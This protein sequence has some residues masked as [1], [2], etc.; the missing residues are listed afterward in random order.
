MERLYQKR[1]GLPGVPFISG[2]PGEDGTGGN[3]VYFGYIN[4][5]FDVIDVSVDSIVRAASTELGQHYTGVY[6][7]S[8]NLASDV[9]PEG[10]RYVEISEDP[11]FPG[12][13]SGSYQ[14]EETISREY[15]KADTA[16]IGKDASGNI[17]PWNVSLGPDRWK[18]S[19]PS[20]LM[21]THGHLWPGQPWNNSS[22]GP[23]IP[24]DGNLDTSLRMMPGRY[25]LSLA[26]KNG[27]DLFTA[28]S[29]QSVYQFAL[30]P[31]T[32]FYDK[33][34]DGFDDSSLHNIDNPSIG[35]LENDYASEGGLRLKTD[36]IKYAASVD[37][38]MQVPD[39][40]KEDIKAGDVIYFYT[41]EDD[42]Q[43]TGK[44]E[45]MTVITE[46]LEKCSYQDLIDNAVMTDPFSFK[47]FDEKASTKDG[48]LYSTL[49]AVTG[50]Y[51]TENGDDIKD[52][53]AYGRNMVNLL[54]CLGKDVTFHSGTLSKKNSQ[55][56][57]NMMLFVQNSGDTINSKMTFL[58]KPGDDSKI[59]IDTFSSKSA[60]TPML[61][62][63]RAYIRKDN[64]GNVETDF[65]ANPEGYK[66][67]DNGYIH[68]LDDSDYVASESTFYVKPSSYFYDLDSKWRLGV[69][70]ETYNQKLYYSEGR[71]VPLTAKQMKLNDNTV[72]NFTWSYDYSG[73]TAFRL[74]MKYG[75]D[76]MHVITVWA[77]LP[78]SL[79]KTSR[80][81]K[82]QYSIEAGGFVLSELWPSADSSSDDSKT[83]EPKFVV[84]SVSAESIKDAP[85]DIIIPYEANQDIKVF[86]NTTRIT[87]LL[88]YSS[89][90]V[91]GHGSW[92]V[93]TMDP[94]S[95]DDVK[96][97]YLTIHLK[98]TMTSNLPTIGGS[99]E[100]AADYNASPGSNTATIANG[101]DIFN[102]LIEGDSI[103]TEDRSL[104]IS[105]NYSYNGAHHD[106]FTKVVQPG[107]KDLRKIPNVGVSIKKDIRSLEDANRSDL[108]VTS[109]EFQF[110]VEVSID[111]FDQSIWGS[112]VPED[113]IRL[114]ME[115]RNM[116]V[117]YDFVEK[118]GIQ[119][120]QQTRT[121]HVNTVADE[122]FNNNYVRFKTYVMDPSFSTYRGKTQSELDDY[123][124]KSEL[125]SAQDNV[126]N[127]EDGRVRITA[128]QFGTGDERPE[129]IQDNIVVTISN[130]KFSDIKNGK[131]CF[132]VV[133]EIGNPL[134]SLLF[135]RFYVSN[136]WID[137][138]YTDSMGVY[139]VNKFYVGTN[140]L[141][142][143]Q[144]IGSRETYDYMFAS[145]TFNAFICPVSMTS[146]PKENDVDRVIYP[147][148]EGDYNLS[149]DK[150]QISLKT[151][152]YVPQTVVNDNENLTDSEKTSKFVKEQSLGW[153]NFSARKKYF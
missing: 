69:I 133:A 32:R 149:G 65:L 51:S 89:T 1:H 77:E 50:Y 101:C 5:F 106:G 136:M 63:S 125:I 128:E 9:L 53:S 45:Y 62:V 68:M 6:D 13:F 110:F 141:A 43:M 92:C 148:A 75:Y 8:G 64:I 74:D 151:S 54:G 41:D 26:D 118:Y 20:G 7:S 73:E 144:Q 37:D 17:N 145:E 80:S 58:Q 95:D 67:D 47:F 12:R 103:S 70:C 146:I 11:E 102:T 100:K 84:A 119:R 127:E 138:K 22:V 52:V 42:F 21:D 46:S 147:S 66:T 15:T 153:F 72:K 130:V 39:K 124:E 82:A 134:F 132:R 49:P 71:F 86:I 123:D 116:T 33:P 31:T 18:I 122:D 97:G 135:F 137:Y 25:S 88:D 19:D 40:L 93:V 142:V 16:A 90:D 99:Y 96:D 61:K 55:E 108:G 27:F 115:I 81:L 87:P 34:Y 126:A 140:N 129:G 113:D 85:V 94:I 83:T 104:T 48:Y 112:Y 56:D 38:N 120:I 78:G 121:F 35:E 143:R 29:G 30:T 117:D 10:S 114:N 76:T 105:V 139:K 44:V 131:F 28:T 24:F 109:N 107:Y 152:L 4:E 150:Q 59:I 3:N 23:Y 14:N 60:K 79:K 57:N 2:K 91:A 98:M 111:D 36:F